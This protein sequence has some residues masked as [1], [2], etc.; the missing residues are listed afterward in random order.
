MR[1]LLKIPLFPVIVVL[2]IIVGIGRLLCLVSGIVLNSI[3]V[4]ILL[5]VLATVALLGEPIWTG[6]KMAG[7]AWLISSFGLPLILMF[8]V[9]LLGAAKDS[10]KA[11]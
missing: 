7:L 8:L 9:E 11:V 4:I 5:I 3:A 6:L 10:L 1:I 2:T